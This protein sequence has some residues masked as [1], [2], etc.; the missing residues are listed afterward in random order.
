M[1]GQAVIRIVKKS[2]LDYRRVVFLSPFLNNY[3][4]ATLKLQIMSR[5]MF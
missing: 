4:S 5:L 2:E 3:K 1:S